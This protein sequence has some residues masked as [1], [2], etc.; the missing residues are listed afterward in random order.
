VTVRRAKPEDAN[1]LAELLGQLGY[2]AEVPSV[3]R[4]LERLAASN[5]DE[6]WV[7]EGDGEIVG[8]VGLHVSDS[9][10]HDGPVGKISEIVVEERLRG[11][12]IGAAL[13]K[14]A[15]R[16]ARR[17][18]CVLLFLTTAERRE[19]AHRF[20]RRLGFEETGRRFAKSLA[21]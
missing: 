19:D 18:G 7:A 20:Y 21:E 4:R 10:E 3:R 2:A 17:R 11:R 5:A 13:M 16:E 9:L 6:T 15:E 8:L 1:R 12:G 14:K